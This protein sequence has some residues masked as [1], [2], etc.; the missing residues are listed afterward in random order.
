MYGRFRPSCDATNNPIGGRAPDGDNTLFPN[1]E[2]DDDHFE[3]EA[4][5]DEPEKP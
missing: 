4:D 5:N 2:M 3:T 1:G